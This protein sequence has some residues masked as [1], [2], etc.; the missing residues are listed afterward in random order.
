MNVI[1]RNGQEVVFNLDKIESAIAKANKDVAPQDQIDGLGIINIAT[2]VDGECQN[3]KRAVNVEEIQDFV[4]D[5]LLEMGYYRLAKA[6]MTYRYQHALMRQTNTTDGKILSLINLEN[7][8]I[9]QENSNKNPVIVSTQRD[10]MA[11]EVS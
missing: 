6:Y 8:E 3:L 1:K 7:E 5:T 2:A 9:K 4:E 10:Y 11:G